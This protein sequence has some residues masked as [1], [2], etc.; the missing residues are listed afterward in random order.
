MVLT[1]FKKKPGFFVGF[2]VFAGR[3]EGFIWAK[4]PALRS[5]SSR[6]WPNRAW[7]G[8]LRNQRSH[9]RLDSDHEPVLPLDAATPSIGRLLRGCD[10]QR[11][12][13]RDRRREM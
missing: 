4:T 8:S 1:T 7:L 13:S 2:S 3:R 9:P 10:A 11:K 6:D 5:P 12:A